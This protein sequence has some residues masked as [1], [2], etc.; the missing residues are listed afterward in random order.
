VDAEDLA[1]RVERGDRAALARL[2]TLVESR[3]D[4][5]R[6]TAAR[7]AQGLKRE[8]VAHRIGVSG[9][10][11][12]GKSTLIETLGMAMTEAGHRVAVLA[13]DPSSR[14]T[15]GSLLGDQARMPRLS[16]C[17]SAFVRPTASG[18][19][20]GG[21]HARTAEVVEVLEA[22]GFDRI[23][24]ETVGVGQSELEVLSAVDTLL[25][26]AIPGSGDELQGIKRGI[27][28]AADLVWVNKSDGETVTLAQTAQRQLLAALQ[29]Q[30]PRF[31]GWQVP[32]LAG[33][34]QLSTGVP[35]LVD[36]LAA[37][38]EH[39]EVTG[40]WS[41]Q[42][43]AQRRERVLAGAREGAWR[44]FVADPTRQRA[45]QSALDAADDEAAVVDALVASVIGET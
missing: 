30:R 9:P 42:R 43:R 17:A 33:S 45:L 7:I 13:V 2:V 1:Q 22:V 4:I 31:A 3:R 8:G 37:H 12:A 36:A 26:L 38:R 24:V 40:Q 29:L 44:A 34:A 27:V 25:L 21:V 10:P 23:L 35:A 6:A 20:L 14:R 15:G 28:E 41:S 5:D 18:A 11:G 32:V 39:L 19:T 16:Q